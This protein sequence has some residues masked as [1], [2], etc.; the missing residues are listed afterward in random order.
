MM[1]GNDLTRVQFA[2]V[3]WQPELEGKTLKYWAE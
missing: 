3:A 2:K 1:G